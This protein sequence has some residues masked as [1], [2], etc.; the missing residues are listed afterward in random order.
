MLNN[1]SSYKNHYKAL[2]LLG[3]PIMIGQLGTIILGFADTIMIGRHSTDELAAS[4]FVNNVF[5]LAIIF[6]QG[7]SYGLTPIV[8]GFYGRKELPL[9]GQALK[10]SLLANFLLSLLVM[11]IMFI[12]YLNVERLGQ[13]DELM[14]FIKP[15][16][17][18]LLIS[19]P[20]VM[21]F[22][23]FKQFT[24]GIT[25][26]QAAMWILIGGNLFNIAGN[27]VLIYGKFGFPEWGLFGAG[28]STLISRIL[29][30]IAFAVIIFSGKKFMEY[31]KGFFRLPV[32]KKLFSKIN[33]LGWPIGLQMGMETASFSLSAVMIGWL[34]TIALASHQVMITISTFAFMLYS[35]MGAAVAVR[36]SN[37]QGQG[38]LPNTKRAAY[39]G[40]HLIM[41]MA[42]VFSCILFLSR[43]Y[44]GSIFTDNAD[45]SATVVSLTIPLLLYQFGDALQLNFANALRG[46]ADVKPMMI[47]AF[48]SYFLV[49]LPVGYFL[50]F[51]LEWGAF[52]VWMAFPFGLTTAGILLWLRFRSKT[53]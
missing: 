51:I 37:F 42:I 9:A 25:Y 32:T 43:H 17:I 4:S 7:F 46:M 49:S 52:G 6:S 8:G 12:L 47:I 26:T 21:L 1:F 40:F 5:N 35:G 3:I 19:L 53:R 28:L 16:F 50:G 45:V 44:L 20:F 22:N 34:G 15:Y 23:S 39:S 36:V 13:P 38:D 24:D 18:I 41:V 27:Y 2:L 48:I 31:R 10:S 30:V 29:M 14:H 11:L 33:A